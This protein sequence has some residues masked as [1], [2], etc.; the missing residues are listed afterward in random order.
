MP[1]ERSANKMHASL[2]ENEDYV[3]FA[4]LFDVLVWLRRPYHEGL[5][6]SED[7]VGRL[8][9]LLAPKKPANYVSAMQRFRVRFGGVSTSAE[10]QAEFANCVRNAAIIVP[11]PE[12]VV[13]RPSLYFSPSDRLHEGLEGWY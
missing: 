1:S 7:V 4:Y 8:L 10:L 5:E 2:A 11:R 9:C 12:D 6:A 3:D 13:W